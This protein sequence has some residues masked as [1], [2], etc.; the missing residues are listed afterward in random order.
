MTAAPAAATEPAFGSAE[1]RAGNARVVIVPALGGRIVSLELGG[2]EWLW[3]RPRRAHE[4]PEDGSSYAAHGDTGGYDELFP[5]V[6]PCTLPGT[7]ARYGGLALPDHGELWS[8]PSTFSLETREEGVHAICG[9]TGRRMPYRFLRRVFVGRSGEVEMRYAVTN[10]GAAPLPFVWAAQV[11]M[12]LGPE[13]RLLLPDGARAR[14]CSQRGV[15]LGGPGAEMRWPRVVAGGKIVDLSSPDGVTRAYACKVF[16][17]AGVGLAAVQEGGARLELHCDATRVPYM[18][19]LVDKRPWSPF[20]RGRPA[21]RIA[22]VPGI[23][24]PDSLAEGVGAWRAAAWL[25][26]AETREWTLVWK[27]AG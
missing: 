9:W 5:T 18:G 23:G 24:A 3:R 20:R 10:D 21:H 7:V 26:P 14:V 1:L 27:A 4:V 19:V 16:V 2:R 17:D 12:P 15:E 11:M 6:A 8:Q 13:T 25:Q 22:L